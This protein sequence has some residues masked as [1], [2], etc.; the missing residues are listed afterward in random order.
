MIQSV[1]RIP[2]DLCE[3]PGLS[4]VEAVQR[5]GYLHNPDALTAP[6]VT[7]HLRRQPD[8]V[9]AWLR[10]S[11]DKRTPAGWYILKHEEHDYEIGWFPGG[12]R[13]RF[14]D[15]AVACSEFIVRELRT[16]RPYPG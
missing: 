6:D 11:G 13:L 16:F 1:C 2:I 10:Y 7:A 8:L 5:S 4:V 9:D 15:P 3:G 12:E 14:S